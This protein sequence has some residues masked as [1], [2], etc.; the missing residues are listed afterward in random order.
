M[1]AIETSTDGQKSPHG[2]LQ[3]RYHYTHR[4]F[5]FGLYRI[6]LAQLYRCVCTDLYC[7]V[8]CIPSCKNPVKIQE[9]IL[10]FLSLVV[11]FY[12]VEAPLELHFH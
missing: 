8:S 9:A 2:E 12:S 10:F 5:S 11:T 4:M 1:S 6:P 7:T 3:Y